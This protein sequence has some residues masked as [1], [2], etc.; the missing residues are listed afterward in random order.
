MQLKK[1]IKFKVG[2]LRKGKQ[3][4][5]DLALINSL[6]VTK[7]FIDLSIRNKTTSKTKLHQ[8]GYKDMRSKYDL[9]SCVIAQSREKAS[10]MIRSWKTNKRRLNKN[11]PI[12]EPKALK[13]RYD[14]MVF[15]IVETE[16]KEYHFWVSILVK[17]GQQG[18]SNNRIYIPIIANSDYQKEYLI[19]LINNKYK[20]GS[21]D[22]VK[23]GD[24]YF[25]H[26]VLKKEVEFEQKENYNPIGIDVGI[27]NL[28]VI[29]VN[30]K[31]KFFSGKR[32]IAKKKHLNKV[33]SLYQSRNNLKMLE[34]IKGREQRYFNYTNHNISSWVV[35]NAKQLE[36][37]IVVMEDLTNIL[38]TTRVRKKQRYIHQTWAFK[39]LQSMIQYKALWEGIPVIYIQPQYTSQVCPKCLSTNKRVKHRYQCKHCGYEANADYVASVNIAKKFWEGISFPETASINNAVGF[40]IT[41]PQAVINREVKKSNIG[42]NIL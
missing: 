36:N 10:E 37:P 31:P 1:T 22:L 19:D 41:E 4:L 29:N 30:G 9:P 38:E 28:A 25:V 11:I 17:K 2:E 18:K 32:S 13:I 35:E 8:I 5:I 20:K 12:P 26:I 14:N 40:S 16:N 39:K 24:D 15:D 34:A 3:E 7:E 21:A 6:N 23:K 27:N 33:K 42:G